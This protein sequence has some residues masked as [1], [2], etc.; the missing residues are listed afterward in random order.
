MSAFV[1][2]DGVVHHTDSTYAR[3]VEQL[4]GTLGYLDVAPL[5]R[6][7]EAKTLGPGGTVTTSTRPRRRRVNDRA[8]DRNPGRV[9]GRARRAA[10]GGEGAHAPQRRACPQ[11]AGAALGAGREG[12]QPRD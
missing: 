4:M 2:Q 8:Q 3:S 5:G 9:A 10:Q 12:G 11:A 1:L 6:N 7:E